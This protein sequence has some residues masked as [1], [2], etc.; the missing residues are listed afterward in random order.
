QLLELGRSEDTDGF[1]LTPLALRLSTYRNGVSE[2]HG[3]VAREMW[4]GLWPGE[5]TPVDAITNG[6]HLGTWLAPELAELLRDAGVEPEA[7]PEWASWD[8]AHRL[9]DDALLRTHGLLK[10]RLAKLTRL[11][12]DFLTIGFARRFATYKR[13]GLV[14]TDLERL[15]RLPVQLVV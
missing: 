3:E 12:P 8:A 5:P 13:A 10:A 4:A 2:L 9:D 11:D 15:L 6:V 14:Y 7:P 1:G